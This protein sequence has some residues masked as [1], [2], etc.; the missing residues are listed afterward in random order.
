MHKP[1]ERCNILS[2]EHKLQLAVL[3]D[4]YKAVRQT[5]EEAA[6]H[7]R[8]LSKHLDTYEIILKIRNTLFLF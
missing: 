4:K 6:H 1:S 8:L 2:G 7:E 5:D 3:R